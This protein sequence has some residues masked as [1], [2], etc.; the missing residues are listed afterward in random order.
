MGARL[1]LATVMAGVGLLWGFAGSAFGHNDPLNVPPGPSVAGGPSPVPGYG[2]SAPVDPTQS[3][4]APSPPPAASTP[5]AQLP[6]R[7]INWSPPKPSGASVS[8]TSEVVPAVASQPVEPSQ[9]ENSARVTTGAP[10]HATASHRVRRLGTRVHSPRP[11]APRAA[12]TDAG[13]STWELWAVAIA[14]V[15]AAAVVLLRRRGGRAGSLAGGSLPEG[16]DPV[17]AELQWIIA[18]EAA[19]SRTRTEEREREPASL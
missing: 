17:E 11:A 3:Q 19:A 9:A 10:R 6:T 15:A 14:A 7:P 4:P 13:G 16:P 12:A 18:A 5:V 8:H 2:S 1:I